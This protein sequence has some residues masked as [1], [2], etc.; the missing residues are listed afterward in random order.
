MSARRILNHLEHGGRV[1]LLVA[2]LHRRQ[3]PP[4]PRPRPVHVGV[5]LPLHRTEPPV[6]VPDA[7]VQL[8]NPSVLLGPPQGV[9][10]VHLGERAV[11][12]PPGREEWG[13]LDAEVCPKVAFQR[14]AT[15]LA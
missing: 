10:G 15:G 8:Q 3:V 4:A 2:P 1:R 11:G 13:V 5:T 6:R 14:L 9:A 12:E 7:P